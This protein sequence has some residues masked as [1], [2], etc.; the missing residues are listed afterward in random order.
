[1]DQNTPM[2][3]MPEET[4]RRKISP[5]IIVVAILV[6]A[7]IVYVAIKLTTGSSNGPEAGQVN[8]IQPNQETQEAQMKEQVYSYTGVVTAV[9]GDTINV[10][11]SANKNASSRDKEL[12]VHTDASTTLSRVTVSSTMGENL[13][14]E[15]LADLIKTEKI[16]VSQVK[17]GD[18][19]VVVAIENVAN[20][21]EFTASSVSV[22]LVK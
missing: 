20:K 22:R 13:T 3:N 18:E 10:S 1:M 19:V 12:T 8:T 16:T 2:Q 6:I 4:S 14:Q 17:L 9:N 5:V 7:I 15:Q 11:A 21:N